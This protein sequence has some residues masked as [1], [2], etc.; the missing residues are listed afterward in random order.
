LTL[1]NADGLPVSAA[2]VSLRSMEFDRDVE[3]WVS[4][5]RLAWPVQGARTDDGGEFAIDGIPNGDYTWRVTVASGETVSG[6]ATVP[7][8]AKADVVAISP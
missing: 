7:P 8:R 2:A 3:D 6:I 5:G 1:R 4:E